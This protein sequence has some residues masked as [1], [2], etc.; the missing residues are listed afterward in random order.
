MRS[1]LFVLVALV[2][3]PFAGHAEAPADFSGDWVAQEGGAAADATQPVGDDSKTHGHGGHGRAGGM[4]GGKGDHHRADAAAPRGANAVT[5]DSR[6]TAHALIIRQDENVFDI[7]ADGRRIAYRFDG[8][9]N[10]GPQYGGTVSIAWSVP[11]MVIE[12]HPD[13]GGEI[14]ERYALSQDGRKLT[15][16]ARTQHGAG[17]PAAEVRRVFVRHGDTPAARSAFTLP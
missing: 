2:V 9:N 5:S 13:G 1:L 17:D 11:E 10:Y 7:E 4:G 6:V 14:E 15:L 16:I 12:T 8:R 3:A